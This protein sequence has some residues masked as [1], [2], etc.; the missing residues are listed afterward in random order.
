MNAHPIPL[1]PLNREPRGDNDQSPP[2][3][4]DLVRMLHACLR[5]ADLGTHDERIIVWLARWEASTVRTVASWLERVRLAERDAAARQIQAELANVR[6]EWARAPE[7]WRDTSGEAEEAYRSGLQRA[8]I[9]IR[10]I[11]EFRVA[12][13]ATDPGADPDRA[14]G[15]EPG[16]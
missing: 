15:W 4:A 10:D 9:I 11:T 2:D 1:G 16:S 14:T 5:D 8:A 7:A 6:A 13:D 3:E 12:G